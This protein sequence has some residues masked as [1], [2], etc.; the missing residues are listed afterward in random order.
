MINQ[1]MYT[2]ARRGLYKTTAGYDTV[3]KSDGLTD[4]FVKNTLHPL[5]V[6]G[7]GEKAVTLVN[8]PDGRVFFG[9]AVPV[10]DFT[11]QRTAF[12]MHNYIL[13]SEMAGNAENLMGIEFATEPCE[14]LE[15]LD[16]LPPN[17]LNTP[18]VDDTEHLANRVAAAVIHSN[19]IYIKHDNPY[20]VT[21]K[22][23]EF[24]PEWVRHVFGF[25]T[26]SREAEKRS[27]VHLVFTDNE[28]LLSKN[29]DLSTVDMGISSRI[30]RL[31]YGQ[32]FAEMDFWHLRMPHRR[33][34][35]FNAERQWLDGNLEKLSAR[36]FAAIP[37]AFIKRGKSGEIPTF[38][39]AVSILKKASE[40]LLANREV[41]LRY[42]LGNYFLPEELHK[43]ICHIF[44]RF[45]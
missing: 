13:P 35:L 28:D 3:A 42:L 1:H 17:P 41:D 23:Y 22:I 33:E 6:F 9:Q 40:A 20:A 37:S 15:I 29:V 24:L 26:Y 27:G 45:Y 18:F 11:G 5:C 16:N 34:V 44:K 10:T 36:Q 38:H 2:R 32:F 8:L 30:S 7:G 25:C 12:F 14:R 21:A 19:K 4:D 31:S 39:V 43:R